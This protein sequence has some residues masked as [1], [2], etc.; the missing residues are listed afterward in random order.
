MARISGDRQAAVGEPVPLKHKVDG[1]LARCRRWVTA[2]ARAGYAARGVMYVLIGGLAV[3]AALGWHG[4]ATGMTGALRRTLWSLPGK[5]VVGFVVAGL[6]AHAVWNLILAL[7]DPETRLRARVGGPGVKSP[8]ARFGYRFAR[9]FE[10]VIHVILVVMALGMITGW[11]EGGGAADDESNVERW[12]AALM[13]VTGGAIALAG[14]GV[15][16]GL[17]GASEVVRAYR[18]ELDRMLR[19]S[20]IQR[21]PRKAVMWVSR[22]GI[23]ARGLVFVVVGAWLTW[24]A[25][26]ANARAAKGLGGALRS[27]Q[28][29]AWGPWVLGV[30]AAGLVAYGAYELLRSAYRR[31][32]PV[33]EGV[34]SAEGKVCEAVG[35]GPGAT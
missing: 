26:T 8:A 13:S 35:D 20:P 4:S 25:V 27:L 15:G 34:V 9:F 23:A 14:I 6:A 12:S 22:I 17:F 2:L 28:D 32:Q 29:W 3:L 21:K 1:V 33:N 16:I 18:S 7:R 31:V 11:S 5:V 24:A 19:L 30:V 10:A